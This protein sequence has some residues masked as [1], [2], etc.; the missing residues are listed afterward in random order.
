MRRPFTQHQGVVRAQAAQR[1]RREPEAEKPF[2]NAAP[3]WPL[4][5]AVI[6]RTTSEMV[7]R[8]D[9]WMSSRV[10]VSIGAAVSES[11]RLM[12][13]PVTLTLMSC[14]HTDPAASIANPPMPSAV[15]TF[16]R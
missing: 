11:T 14:A 12:L 1:D 7:C 13:V 5:F 6:W 8:P 16:F 2:V 4:L 3:I 9:A 10:I 15:A